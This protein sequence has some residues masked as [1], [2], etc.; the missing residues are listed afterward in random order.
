MKSILHEKTLDYKCL[1][2]HRAAN[3]DGAPQQ[4]APGIALIKVHF[5]KGTAC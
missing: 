3:R 2:T 1:Q 5:L 4:L